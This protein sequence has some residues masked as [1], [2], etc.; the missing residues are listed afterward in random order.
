MNYNQRTNLKIFVYKLQIHLFIVEKINYH[1]KINKNLTAFFF[2][3][4]K[5]IL[6]FFFFYFFLF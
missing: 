3:E 4:N 2:I 5:K 6:A 1:N